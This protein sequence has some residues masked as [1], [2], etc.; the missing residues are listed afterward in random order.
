MC[1]LYLAA[2]DKN[3]VCGDRSTLIS[4]ILFTLIPYGGLNVNT[5]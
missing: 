2:E 5:V 3:N 1:V 4:K